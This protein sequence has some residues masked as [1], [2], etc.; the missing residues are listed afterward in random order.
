MLVLIGNFVGFK[1]L[2]SCPYEEYEGIFIFECK[3]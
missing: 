3:M 1:M 2:G